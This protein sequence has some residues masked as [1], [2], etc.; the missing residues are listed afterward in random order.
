[1]QTQAPTHALSY[2]RRAVERAFG[3]PLDQIFS[4]FEEEPVASGSIAQVGRD[5]HEGG[6]LGGRHALL[7]EESEGLCWQEESMMCEH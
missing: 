2:T 5:V 3:L 7:S 1:M 6:W 4:E